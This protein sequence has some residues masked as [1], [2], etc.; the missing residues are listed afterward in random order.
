M[1]I[2]A[3]LKKI[4]TI[5]T[6][7]KLNP[8]L[9]TIFRLDGVNFSR[10]LKQLE[11]NKPYDVR[12]T[13]SIME[14]GIECFNTFAFSLCYVGYDEIIYYLKPVTKE[15]E[16]NGIEY[17]FSG[18]IQKMVSMLAGKVSVIFYAKL[19]KYFSYE[20]LLKD[21]PYWECKVLQFNNF[22]EIS[23]TLHNRMGSTLK[24]S[25]TLFINN[26]LQGTDLSS[27]DAIKKI[28]IE[29]QIDFNNDVSDN[30]KFGC[31]ITYILTEFEKNIKFENN[32]E[33][34]LI[35][36]IKKFPI[37]QNLNQSDILNI[38]YE[39]LL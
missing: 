17:D 13:N 24:N 31:I 25:R 39:S 28:Q 5:D 29:K 6:T 34:K 32:E 22:N 1:S 8:R 26:Y 19:I 30:N 36:F 20:N 2:E 3:N 23:E 35:K 21:F 11:L 38:K 9:H 15:E 10:Y 33:F 37:C 18:R 12:L 16:D 14:T 4:V 27:K 7:I